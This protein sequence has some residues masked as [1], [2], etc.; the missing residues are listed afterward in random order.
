MLKV[1]SAWLGS[2][3]V[4]LLPAALNY[5]LQ[6]FTILPDFS[7]YGVCILFPCVHSSDRAHD[8]IWAQSIL[9]CSV[10]IKIKLHK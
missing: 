6:M 2:D 4:D 3:V 5:V 10:R 1:Q 8:I 7:V 9:F